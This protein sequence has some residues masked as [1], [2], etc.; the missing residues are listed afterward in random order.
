MISRV[1]D[2]EEN[3]HPLLS[4]YRAFSIVAVGALCPRYA[5]RNKDA[6]TLSRQIT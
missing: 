1:E 4:P 3:I 6:D 5:L 2:L